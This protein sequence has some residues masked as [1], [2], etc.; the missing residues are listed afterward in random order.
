LPA[1]RHHIDIGVNP[2]QVWRALTTPEGLTSW[3]VD[4]ARVDAR[5][6][7]RVVLTSQDDAG[8]T[9]EERGM[10]L[11]FTPTRKIEIA[12]DT[13]S[14]APTKGTRVQ[15]QIA[16][17]GEDTRLVLT[18]SG[19]GPLDDPEQHDLMNRAWKQALQALRDILEKSPPVSG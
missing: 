15:F 19:G 13:Q 4:E 16:K 9:Q 2:R 6:G 3:W 1:I 14:K 12:W 5:T 8:N 11:E 18:H 10:F 7:G 17:S